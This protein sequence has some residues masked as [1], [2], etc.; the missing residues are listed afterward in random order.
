M[1]WVVPYIPSDYSTHP[2]FTVKLRAVVARGKFNCEPVGLVRP[3]LRV[4]LML[5]H[6]LP[7]QVLGSHPLREV[8]ERSEGEALDGRGGTVPAA[9]ARLAAQMARARAAVCAVA[10]PE[11]K[12]CKRYLTSN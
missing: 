10:V 8:A 5:A 2:A 9:S 1:V 6:I 12:Q 4:A 3:P 11:R 7:T